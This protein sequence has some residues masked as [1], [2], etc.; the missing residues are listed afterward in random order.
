MSSTAAANTMDAAPAPAQE[1]A[2]K[3]TYSDAE[4]IACSLENPEACEACQ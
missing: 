2:P 1:A 4:V 3:K